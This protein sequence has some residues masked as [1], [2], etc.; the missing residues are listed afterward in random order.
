MGAPALKKGNTQ[1]Q[2]TKAPGI[3]E[4]PRNQN[5]GKQNGPSGGIIAPISFS[6]KKPR[7]K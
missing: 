3:S 4:T 7:A 5:K 1:L 2:R 6:V